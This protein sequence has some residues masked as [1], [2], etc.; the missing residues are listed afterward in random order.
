MYTTWIK[1]VVFEVEK[2]D[3]MIEEMEE[4]LEIEK[5][6]VLVA[7]CSVEETDVES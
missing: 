4:L 6:P 2:E 1:Q 7:S 3:G 5:R